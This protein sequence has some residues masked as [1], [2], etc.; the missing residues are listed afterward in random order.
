M[1]SSYALIMIVLAFLFI[2]A[3]AIWQSVAARRKYK[4]VVNADNRTIEE[5]VNSCFGRFLWEHSSGPGKINWRRRSMK[6]DGAVISIDFEE[7]DSGRS[8]VYI[9]MSH[10]TSVM[11]LVDSRGWRASKKVA[12]RLEALGVPV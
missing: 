7:I 10:W 6:G 9:W 4:V 3:L 5:T 8:V 12:R 2:L 11:G 1:D